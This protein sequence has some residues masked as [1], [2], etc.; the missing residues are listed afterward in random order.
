MAKQI[1]KGEELR[2]LLLSGVQ[3]LA[4]TVTTTLGPKGR[5][6]GIEK[7][8]VDASVV[9]DGVSVAKE[10]ELEDPFE[11]MGAQLV[12]QAA[13]KTAD[14]AGDGTTTSTLLAY[15]MIREGFGKI[16]EGANPMTMK[17]GMEK[18]LEKILEY[19]TL[20][21][22]SVTTP[23]ELAQ[24]ATISSADPE[25]GKV[26][27][28]AMFKVGKDGVITTEEYAGLNIDV[29]YKE[30]MQFDKGY[31]SA[32]FVTNPDKMEA[33][34]L[35]PYIL[36]TDHTIT[37]SQEIGLFL[38]LFLKGTEQKNIVIICD[39]L[40]GAA[41]PTVLINKMRGNINPLAV[42]APGF[43]ERRKDYL[44]DIATLT[45]GKVIYKD[46]TP[47]EKVLSIK[48]DPTT[49]TEQVVG[50]EVLGKA[51]SVWADGETTKIVG[52]FGETNAI[53]ARANQIRDLINKT[54]SE[55]EKEKLKE[56][57][58]KLIS[59]AAI[60]KVGART[61][62]ELSDRKE[63]VIDAVEATKA[64]AAEGIV[65]GGGVTLNEASRA[66]K[67]SEGGDFG[68]GVEIVKQAL[69][70]PYIKLLENAAID[71][72]IINKKTITE[73]TGVNVMNGEVGNMF[74]MGIID[75]ARV[76]KEAIANAV[77]VAAMIL[78]MEA[79]IVKIP[80]KID[81]NLAS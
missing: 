32:Q 57:L 71:Q 68:I 6:V 31:V 65:A 39:R 72:T 38:E 73:S 41:L 2:K 28:E 54:D 23:D 46:Q 43:A 58:A 10:I 25:I 66:L 16:N 44:E 76:T 69:Q 48:T 20:K 79:G 8:W 9:H 21:A 59:G 5:N 17:A 33:E 81:N 4:D 3:Q 26:I 22:K 67:L 30:G 78:T 75:P 15:E 49:R 40:D 55:F 27:G 61:E 51:E 19:I 47:L 50:L 29:E 11:N 77:S 63:R 18:A 13:G 45:G 36:I 53:E 70:K 24:I 35:S 12:R 74:E 14:K 56:R 60:I 64:A 80:E 1:K 52:G 37:S 7:T 62:V 34:V 42:F